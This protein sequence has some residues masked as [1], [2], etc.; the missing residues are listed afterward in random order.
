M[1]C[2]RCIG[3]HI[4][5]KGLKG[6]VQ[7]PLSSPTLLEMNSAIPTFNLYEFPTQSTI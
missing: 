1:G 5:G 2:V 6:Y 7:G 3:V 4:L